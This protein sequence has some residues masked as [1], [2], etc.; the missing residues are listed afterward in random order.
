MFKSFKK[1]EFLYISVLTIFIGAISY[2]LLIIDFSYDLLFFYSVTM[3]S[4]FLLIY[5]N[6]KLHKKHGSNFAND[7]IRFPVDFLAS[8]FVFFG[9]A[10][11]GYDTYAVGKLQQTEIASKLSLFTEKVVVDTWEADAMKYPSLSPVYEKI[12]STPSSNSGHFL[13]EEEWNALNIPAPYVPYK[14]NEKAWHFSAKFIQ[15]LVNIVRMF[16]L[17]KKFKVNN[18][19]DLARSQDNMYAGWMTCFRM[20]LRAP[21]VRNVWEQYKYRHVNPNFSAWVKY[22]VTDPIDQDPDFFL[23]QKAKWNKAVETALT[24][25]PGKLMELEA[26]LDTIVNTLEKSVNPNSKEES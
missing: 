3:S 21:I 1:V 9:I 17:E 23:K 16:H 15:E 26:G 24:P 8:A 22:F 14:G 13:T 25:E 12:F 7:F 10:K 19:E 6:W 20:Y 5:L 2:H 4:F 11:I 18:V